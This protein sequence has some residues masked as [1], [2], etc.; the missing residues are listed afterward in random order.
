MACRRSH[1]T[2]YPS[3]NILLKPMPFLIPSIRLR[4]RSQLYKQPQSINIYAPK[5]TFGDHPDRCLGHTSTTRFGS[6]LHVER[7]VC[8]RGARA[9]HQISSLL[10]ARPMRRARQLAAGDC[11]YHQQQSLRLH[12]ARCY[13]TM[14]LRA[15]SRTARTDIAHWPTSVQLCKPSP[16]KSSCPCPL[17]L[18]HIES[19]PPARQE[20]HS[21][22]CHFD[23]PRSPSRGAYRCPGPSKVASNR[24][25]AVSALDPTVP[26]QTLLLY[27]SPQTLAR[28]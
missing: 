4:A 11:Q 13:W 3:R 10:R 6:E 8:N 23:H 24:R 5:R 12:D 21:P 1:L 18:A 20:P 17:P 9:R 19:I 15:A 7:E 2:S 16:C 22:L 25:R 26:S 28:P 14:G 27:R